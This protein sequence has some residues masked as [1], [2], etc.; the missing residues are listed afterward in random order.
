MVLCPVNTCK[1]WVWYLHWVFTY[2]WTIVHLLS[3]VY[4]AC[5]TKSI[6]FFPIILMFKKSVLYLKSLVQGLS[7]HLRWKSIFLINW[8]TYDRYDL[9]PSYE[10][11]EGREMWSGVLTCGFGMSGLFSLSF[12]FFFLISSRWPCYQFY[13]Y[14]LKEKINCSSRD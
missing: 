14:S 13:Q 7:D 11:Q 5:W 4:D 9:D 3:L 1:M 2:Y 8:K 12:F 6:D 10:N